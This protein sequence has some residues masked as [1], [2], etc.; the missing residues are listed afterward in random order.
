MTTSETHTS[1]LSTKPQ[2]GLKHSL[3]YSAPV[4]V[5][6]LLL[7]P[8][9]IL[10]G[11]YA[12]FFGL[13]LTTIA[14]ALLVGRI[15]DAVTDPAVGFLSDRAYARTGKRAQLVV[16]GAILL[17][18]SGYFLYV[19]TSILGF[20]AFD[21]SAEDGTSKVS[22]AYFL[23]WLVVTYCAWTLF[24]I[25]HLAWGGEL[26]HS[27]NDKTRL[28]SLR[29]MVAT[30]GG[31]LFFAIPYLPIFETREIT[32]QTL[33]LTIIA[34]AFLMLPLLY[35]S[36][37]HTPKP[38][39]PITLQTESQI[40][41]QTD[42]Q[43]NNRK[44]TTELASTLKSMASNRHFV[45]FVTSFLFSGLGGGCS[46]A[47]AYIFIDSYLGLADKYPMIGIIVSLVAIPSIALWYK[48]CGIFGKKRCWLIGLFINIICFSGFSQ[49]APE[50]SPFIPLLILTTI[51]AVTGP[52]LSVAP[53]SLLSDIIDYG[54]LTSGKNQAGSYFSVFTFLA[55]VNIAIGTTAGLGIAGWYGFDASATVHSTES[56][57]GLQL[58]VI[59][60]PIA[61]MVA[62]TAVVFFIPMNEEQHRKI[63]KELD[64]REA[65]LQKSLHCSQTAAHECST[66]AGL[67]S[68]AVVETGVR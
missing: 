58:S 17:V 66:D 62:A 64:I 44:S 30:L 31:L 22:G 35:I 26:A 36:I 41:P 21:I 4:L 67:F 68:E 37:K 40:E 12:K 16:I 38:N 50:S 1:N 49:L 18:I 10:Q 23:F 7:G 20:D 47:M 52:A 60:L 13:S 45:L 3:A 55:K 14:L 48:L 27:S 39:A 28:Y 51:M 15:V 42:P 6:T 53:L 46:A 5:S 19:P 24:E 29:A 61:L 56:I 57:F 65:E 54:T 33:Q 8:L 9:G 59:Y 11:I 63:R 2:L 34:S 43:T 32:P 25:P